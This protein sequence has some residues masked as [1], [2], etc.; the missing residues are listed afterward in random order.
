MTSM[1]FPPK[2]DAIDLI[3]LKPRIGLSFKRPRL[4]L[5]LSLR[6]RMVLSVLLE[7]IPSEAP[8]WRKALSRG[9]SIG[10]RACN[11]T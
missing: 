10:A 9:P 4:S 11:S 5:S 2:P 8:L 6:L 7:M 1:F 3:H